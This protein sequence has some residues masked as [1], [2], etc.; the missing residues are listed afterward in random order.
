MRIRKSN[1]NYTIEHINLGDDLKTV[2]DNL[3]KIDFLNNDADITILSGQPG[4]GKSTCVREYCKTHKD[5]SRIVFTGRHKLLEE[6]KSIPNFQHWQGFNRMCQRLDDPEI[7]NLKEYWDIDTKICK[8]IG[9]GDC[10]YPTQFGG[11]VN[12]DID[13]YLDGDK[14]PFISKDGEI[15]KKRRMI[16]APNNYINMPF[17]KDFNLV[18]VDEQLDKYNRIDCNPFLNEFDESK[19]ITFKN[20]KEWNGLKNAIVLRNWKFLENNFNKINAFQHKLIEE[21]IECEDLK[22][23]RELLRFNLDIIIESFKYTKLYPDNYKNLFGNIKWYKPYL[24]Y[25]FK[26]CQTTKVVMTCATFN[27][28]FFTDMLEFYNGEFILNKPIK[29]K[30]YDSNI[31]NKETIVA[32]IGDGWFPNLRLPTK[33]KQHL[34]ILVSELGSANIGI[35]CNKEHSKVNDV[36]TFYKGTEIECN[37]YGASAGNNNLENKPILTIIGSYITNIGAL[38]IDYNRLYK[39]ILSEEIL[40]NIGDQEFYARKM[41]NKESYPNLHNYQIIKDVCEMY[42]AMHR[43]RGLLSP[44]YI[45]CFCDV[46]DKIKEEFNYQEY[47]DKPDLWLDISDILKQMGLNI[48]KVNN[49]NMSLFME[50]ANKITPDLASGLSDTQIAKKYNIRIGNSFDT[51]TVRVIRQFSS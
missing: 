42:D 6:Y 15:D 19:Y 26:L 37:T 22:S 33:I 8:I 17:I 51:H 40:Q 11:K 23:V 10:E 18:F 5:I 49:I 9:C 28:K 29:I 43:S 3:S 2:R 38:L 30:I 46:P 24:Y 7:L 39:D 41:I 21:A 36:R 20:K 45:I 14:V 35:V 12:I 44:K 31:S 13:R 47:P 27:L 48:T 16:L 34:E 1:T 25:I 32:K 4:I 50:I